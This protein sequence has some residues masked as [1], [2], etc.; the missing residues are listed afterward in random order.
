MN[1]EQ[2]L[3]YMAG[4]VDGEG[5]IGITR[6][7]SS[8]GRN[9]YYARLT[10]HMKDVGA[11]QI[12]SDFFNI[13]IKH[14]RLGGKN[15]YSF[16]ETSKNLLIALTLL[17]PYLQVKKKQAE[18]VIKLLQNRKENPQKPIFKQ[19]RFRGTSSVPKPIQDYREHL[20]RQTSALNQ[21]LSSK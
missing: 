11:I 8:I 4:I 19:G 12:F 2:K 9:C 17:L 10:I 15:Y 13:P 7:K 5:C 1:Y 18:I 16:Y 14:S 20:Y 6:S 3:A 21:C